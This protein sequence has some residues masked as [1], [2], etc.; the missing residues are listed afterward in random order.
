MK[1]MVEGKIAMV[2]G[3][4]AGMGA[5]DCW[6]FAEEGAAGIVMVDLKVE[7]A[8]KS[9]MKLWPSILPANASP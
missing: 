5:C 4:G 9:P 6:K 3:A 7:A 2:T 1:K 8:E